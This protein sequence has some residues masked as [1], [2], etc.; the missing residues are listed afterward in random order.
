MGELLAKPDVPLIDHLRD[1]LLL[2]HDVAQRMGIGKRLHTQTL[3]ACVLH[4]IG[5][6]TYSFQEHMRSARAF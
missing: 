3:L 6:A 2:G 5:K 4:D 1:V